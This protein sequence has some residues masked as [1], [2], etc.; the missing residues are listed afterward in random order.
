MSKASTSLTRRSFVK[1]T[2]AV[3]A[4]AAAAGATATAGDLFGAGALPAAN[5]TETP[6]RWLLPRYFL[7]IELRQYENRYGR[8]P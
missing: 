5:G 1:T 8:L 6:P 4:F 3:G 2:G 7:A